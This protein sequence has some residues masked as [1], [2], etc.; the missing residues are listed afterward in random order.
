MID[1]PG[2]MNENGRQLIDKSFQVIDKIQS[3]R[4][5]SESDR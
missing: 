4:E 1:K 2:K 5:P 3:D